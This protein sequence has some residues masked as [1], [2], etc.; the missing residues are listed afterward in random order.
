VQNRLEWL[1]AQ[2]PRLGIAVEPAVAAGDVRAATRA[3]NGHSVRA[4]DA[5]PI[6]GNRAPKWRSMRAVA[7]SFCR[8]VRCAFAGEAGA[9]N[10]DSGG[11]DGLIRALACEAP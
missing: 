8:I 2:L 1:R 9:P 11:S 5:P 10:A 6:N 3:R 7:P 4:F